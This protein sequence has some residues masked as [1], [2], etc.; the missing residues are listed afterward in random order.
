MTI[1]GTPKES[2]SG[3]NRVAMTPQ[4]V[5][6]LQKLGFECIVQAGAGKAARFA[7]AE[8]KSPSNASRRYISNFG[9]DISKAARR[10]H[11]ARGKAR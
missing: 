5:G 8:Y 10:V 4:S 6:E 9:S 1:I 7:D 3:E 2:A 11:L